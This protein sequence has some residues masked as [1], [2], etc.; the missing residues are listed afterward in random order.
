MCIY[1]YIYI[2]IYMERERERKIWLVTNTIY[3]YIHM[4]TIHILTI[5]TTIYYLQQKGGSPIHASPT[6]TTELI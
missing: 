3:I 5:D 2:Y 1:I 4:C 6:T